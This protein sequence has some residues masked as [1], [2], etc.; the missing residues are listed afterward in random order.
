MKKAM[1]FLALIFLI[2]SSSLLGGIDHISNVENSK[3]LEN[4]MNG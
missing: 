3:T 2:S 4:G 1:I